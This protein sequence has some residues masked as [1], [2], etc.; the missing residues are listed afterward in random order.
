MPDMPLLWIP[1]LPLLLAALL[2]LSRLRSAAIAL[3]PLAALPALVAALGPDRDSFVPWLLLGVDLRLDGTSRAFLLFS[4][5]LWSVAGLAAGRYLHDDPR[6]TGFFAG[7]LLAMSGNLG[8]LVAADIFSFYAL[9]ALMSFASYALVVHNR[10]PAALR[11]AR[12]YIAFVVLGELALFAGLGLAAQTAQSV[13]LAEIRS[14]DLS[15]AAIALL[16]A[17]LCVKLG[18]VPLHL[19]L[20]LAHAAAPVPASAVLS[21]AMIKA[22]LFG[23]IAL[24]SLGQ[25][26]LPG[27]GLVLVAAGGISILLAAAIGVTQADPK[28]VLAYSS[29][30]QMGLAAIALGTALAAPAAWPAILPALAFFAAHHALA[31]GALFLGVGAV[32]GA[33]S[34]TVRR[35]VLVGLLLP[36]AALCAAPFTAGDLAKSGLKSGITVGGAGE[37]T[38]ALLTVSSLATT[39]LMVRFTVLIWHKEAS[40]PAL[41]SPWAILTG[42]GIAL[43][44]AWPALTGSATALPGKPIETAMPVLAAILLAIAVALA[45]RVFGLG[46]RAVP[47]GEILA[48]FERRPGSPLRLTR[49]P[50]LAGHLSAPH[51]W[52]VVA[53]PTGRGAW[54]SGATAALCVL[55]ALAAIELGGNL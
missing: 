27:F 5:I 25:A 6:R 53:T 48:L 41:T 33:Q 13:S 23:L 46:A 3:A 39:L 2:L 35:L 31:K 18:I 12:V 21:G 28:A 49:L 26:A 15:P 24:L 29:V 51:R 10:D 36:A 11:A 4:G 7:F 52:R 55:V 54:Q 16:M 17:G 47:P 30:G 19:W 42:A 38:L 34:R 50:N 37:I 14:A 9:F 22:G 44:L 43:P 40:G 8:L 45:L 32:A 1:G 20:P